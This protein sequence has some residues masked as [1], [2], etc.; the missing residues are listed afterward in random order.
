MLCDIVLPYTAMLT[1]QLIQEFKWQLFN[2]LLCSLELA[3]L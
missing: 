3:Q 1:L 2:L